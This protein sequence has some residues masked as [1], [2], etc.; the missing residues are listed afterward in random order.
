[1]AEFRL[2]EEKPILKSNSVNLICSFILSVSTLVV[3]IQQDIGEYHFSRLSPG[4][5]T[6]NFRNVD[7]GVSM[8]VHKS[9]RYHS[10]FDIVD[11]RYIFRRRSTLM[12]LSH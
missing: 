11:L 4:E 9:Q 7:V 2:N 12:V 1:M 10:C 5:V 8:D 3:V 6:D